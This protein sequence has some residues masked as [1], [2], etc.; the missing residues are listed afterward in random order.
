M[1]QMRNFKDQI[2]GMFFCALTCTLFLSGCVGSYTSVRPQERER[3]LAEPGGEEIMKKEPYQD[4]HKREELVQLDIEIP[5]FPDWRRYYWTDKALWGNR[6]YV[7][8]GPKAEY[9]VSPEAVAILGNYEPILEDLRLKLTM[10]EKREDRIV[11]MEQPIYD[12]RRAFEEAQWAKES[13]LSTS[14]V[15]KKGESL[16]LIAGYP[17]VYGNPLEWP[18]IFQANRDRVLDPNLIYP[19]QEFRIPRNVKSLTQS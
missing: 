19:G 5:G 4:A 11:V 6:G 2:F 18:K 10:V 15:V 1:R 13:G 3:I 16:W 9:M 14:H 17:E 8:G 12:Q 7:L